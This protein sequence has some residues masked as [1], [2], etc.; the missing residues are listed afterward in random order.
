[1]IIADLLAILSNSK[2]LE[3]YLSENRTYSVKS[4]IDGIISS[5]EIEDVEKKLNKL[6][7]NW[8]ETVFLDTDI[9]K[10]IVYRKERIPNDSL[11]TTIRDD[12]FPKKWK[13][14]QSLREIGASIVIKTVQQ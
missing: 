7:Q 11:F 14:G 8:R 13:V 9:K 1:M 2:K 4:S 5:E 6:L 10:D 3:K 12:N